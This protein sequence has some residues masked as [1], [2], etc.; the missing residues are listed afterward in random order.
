MGSNQLSVAQSYK[1]G[2]SENRH[3]LLPLT[4]QPIHYLCF[5]SG[6]FLSL[7]FCY[8][9]SNLSSIHRHRHRHHLSIVFSSKHSNPSQQTCIISLK[10]CF[11]KQKHPSLCYC[12]QV[13]PILHC[14]FSSE[15]DE[16]EERRVGF[17]V[18]LCGGGWMKL[19]LIELDTTRTYLIFDIS[20]SC[21]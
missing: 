5:T 21:K 15:E 2:S 16:V 4:T 10:L 19:L 1:H 3:V 20:L 18:S 14:T 17:C 11:A 6:S 12:V 7:F 9:T 13:C 8:P